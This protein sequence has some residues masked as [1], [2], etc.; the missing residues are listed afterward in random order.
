MSNPPS[1]NPEQLKEDFPVV[2]LWVPGD[3][4]WVFDLAVNSGGFF[5]EPLN[6]VERDRQWIGHGVLVMGRKL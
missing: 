3:C 2:L 4:H 5:P 6:L 1:F